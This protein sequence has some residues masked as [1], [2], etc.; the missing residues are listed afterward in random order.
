MAQFPDGTGQVD[1]DTLDEGTDPQLSSLYKPR[2]P[3]QPGPGVNGPGG[4]GV[5]G[6]AGAPPANPTPQAPS[7]FQNSLY[8]PRYVDPGSPT[9]ANVSDHTRP[10]SI[11]GIVSSFARAPYDQANNTNRLE[12]AKFQQSLETAKDSAEAQRWQSIADAQEALANGRNNGSM[13]HYQNTVLQR[14]QNGEISET[15]AVALLHGGKP[16]KG[17][18]EDMPKPLQTIAYGNP[19]QPGESDAAAHARWYGLYQ[20]Q[21]NATEQGKNTRAGMHANTGTFKVMTDLDGNVKLLNTKTGELA[22]P[23]DPDA[24]PG[25]GGPVQLTTPGAQKKAPL[26]MADYAA[27]LKRDAL[28]AN[29]FNPLNDQQL[30]GIQDE[31]NSYGRSHGLMPDQNTPRPAPGTAAPQAHVRHTAPAPPTVMRMGTDGNGNRVAQMSDG[32]IKQVDMAGNPVQ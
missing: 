10:G 8:Q 30:A 25:G 5:S 7:S 15:D 1:P 4:S 12:A 11:L 24:P 16:A 18:T 19:Q 23:N 20:N 31:V 21:L 14:L 32:T 13:G 6:G 9:W 29:V 27:Q 22:D 26:S 17:P 2:R 28:K 3:G